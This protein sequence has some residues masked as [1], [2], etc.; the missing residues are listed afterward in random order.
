MGA[1]RARI[2]SQVLR[3]GLLLATVAIGL[4]IVG[5]T[6]AAGLVTGLLFEVRTSDPLVHLGAALVLVAVS[7]VVT[8]APARRAVASDPLIV[9]R[10]D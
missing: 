2:L 10:A 6:L 7:L 3:D 4:G 8:I 5:T 1:T 9:L